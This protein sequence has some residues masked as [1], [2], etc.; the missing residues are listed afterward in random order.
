M[1]ARCTPPPPLYACKVSVLNTLRGVLDA[2]YWIYMGYEQSIQT[3]RLTVL[4]RAG[5][6]AGVSLGSMSLIKRSR[7]VWSLRH[8][9]R[10]S[11]PETAHWISRR[12]K[13]RDRVGWAMWGSRSLV[14]AIFGWGLAEYGRVWFTAACLILEFA[15]IRIVVSSARC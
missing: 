12:V 4:A 14:D 2:K 8:A 9:C 5:I 10:D 11:L 6:R 7:L 15:R 3:E 1:V 13:E